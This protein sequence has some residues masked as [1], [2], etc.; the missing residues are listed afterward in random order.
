MGLNETYRVAAAL[1]AFAVAM[2]IVVAVFVL[3]SS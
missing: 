1:V 3:G 2:L